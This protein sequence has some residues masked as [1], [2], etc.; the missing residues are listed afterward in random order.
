MASGANSGPGSGS[1]RVLD[2]QDGVDHVDLRGYGLSFAGLSVYDSAGG[3][4]VAAAGGAMVL[5]GMS[6][7]LLAQDDF[8]F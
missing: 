3:A 5:S 6:A 8:L 4:V 7:A 2:F 1:D